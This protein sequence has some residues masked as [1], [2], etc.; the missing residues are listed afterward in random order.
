MRPEIL[1]PLFAEIETLPGIGPRLKPLV[2]RLI[3]GE[4]IADLLWHLPSGIIDR[5]FSPPLDETIDGSVVTMDVWVERHEPSPNRRRPYRVICKTLS[6][7]LVLSFFNARAKY[8]NDVLP[9]G[10]KR[11][12]SGKVDHYRD[13]YQITHPDKIGTEAERADIQTVEPVYPMSAG[14]TGKTL[15]KAMR[16]AL[17]LVP[18]LPEWHDPALVARHKWPDLASALR[19]IHN[20]EDAADLSPDHPA[21]KRLAYDELLAN[22]LALALIRAKMRKLGGRV[23]KGSG[24]LRGK[25]ANELPFAMTG[26]Q[27]RALGDIYDDMASE[28]RM[29]RLLQGDVGS[30]KTVVALMA[31]LNAVECGRQAALMAPT[32][33][34]ARQHFETI[35]PL[36]EKIGI[37][38]AILTGRDKG[39][40]RKATLEGFASGDV[41][42]AVGTHALFQ[43][44]VIFADLAF[45][46]VD[47]Q[48]RFGVH[49]RLMLAGKGQA[50]DVLVMTATPIPRTLTL[51]AFGDMEVSRLDEKPPGRKPV[52]TRVLPID[53]VD[54]VI[55]GIGRAMR[56]GTKIYWVCPLVEDSEVLDLQA[57]EERYRILVDLFGEARVGLVHGKMKAKEK[58]DVMERFA[59][60]D[61]SILVATTVIEVGVNVPDATIMVIEHSE[62]FGLAQLHQLRGRIGRG[63]VAST[64]LLLYGSRLGQ[65]SK[66]RLKIMRETEDGFVIAE[67]DLKL[68]GAGEVL[69]TRQSGLQEYR[70]A[71]LELHGD[72]LAIARDDARLIVDRDP[73]LQKTRGEALRLLLYL[74]ERDEAVRYFRSG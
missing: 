32:E 43:D 39:K 23:T 35:S 24:G 63:D 38:C 13:E 47:E 31:M 4:H 12:V 42:I 34:L 50:V 55:S 45:A 41:Q 48:H 2:T 66:A 74:F 5:R 22:Q 57:A 26:A 60:G 62:R 46:V 37:K 29:L 49:Q 68:R 19:T 61:T 40:A 11:I 17:E 69:G 65:V 70:L 28:G 18:E 58:D 1:F 6:G 56:A 27:Q 30:G 67:E 16:A 15:T 7:T 64:C 71:N 72:L 51:T 53:R 44:D 3:G 36:L 8:L 10:E 54:D 25:L 73:D 14:V 52:D 59:H 21:R 20:P 9:V 33:I